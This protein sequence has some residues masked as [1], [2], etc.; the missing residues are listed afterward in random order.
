MS[1][2]IFNW[3]KYNQLTIVKPSLSTSKTE[4]PSMFGDYL[5]QK[6]IDGTFRPTLHGLKTMISWGGCSAKR[7]ANEDDTWNWLWLM[8]CIVDMLLR[9]KPYTYLVCFHFTR[10]LKMK[11]MPTV[12]HRGETIVV[13]WHHLTRYHYSDVIKGAI[14]SQ[15][16][17]LTTVYSTVYSDADQRKHQSSAPLASVRGIH[18]G[19]GTSPHK[20][21]VTRKMFP[22][23]DVIMTPTCLIKMINGTW[24]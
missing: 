3:S 2:W 9:K 18:R 13:V 16:T 1:G 11:D 5:L 4:L 17:S 20:W 22:F 23:D 19:P 12:L 7:I 24:T 21:P 8:L 10:Q 15:I 14:A 6:S